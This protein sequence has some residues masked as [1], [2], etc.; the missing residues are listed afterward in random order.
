[1]HKR[2]LRE[3]FDAYDAN[4]DGTIS[5]I[6]FSRLLEALGAGMS[7]EEIRIGFAEIDTNHSGSIDFKEF[8]A[9]WEQD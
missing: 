1:M 7:D 5:M 4:S 3:T 6:E 8:V 2:E 9:W